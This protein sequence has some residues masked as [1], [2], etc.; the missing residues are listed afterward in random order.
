MRAPAGLTA[1]TFTDISLDGA[2]IKALHVT[3]LRT[4]LDAARAALNLP[5]INYV[6]PVITQGEIERAWGVE[7]L[8]PRTSSAVLERARSA[9]EGIRSVRMRGRRQLQSGRP[10]ENS[11][12]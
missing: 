6:D 11:Y 8:W 5:A 2:I 9:R 12:P 7:P 1:A 10:N 4:A 3:Q